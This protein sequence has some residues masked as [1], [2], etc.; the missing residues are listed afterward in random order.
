MNKKNIPELRFPEFDGEWE[1]KKLGEVAERITTKNKENNKNVLTIS[2][3]YGLINQLNFFNKSVSAKDLTGYYVLSKND[4]AYNKS[5]SNG[6]PM[7][8]F[9]RLTL[10]EKGVVSTLYICFR[11]KPCFSNEF[12]EHCFASGKQ[13]KEIYK[14]AQEGARN[15]GLLNIV[16]NDFFGINLT[17]PSLPEQTKIANFLT[18]VDKKISQLKQKKALLKEYKKGMMQ[19]IFSQKIRFKD[20]NGEDFAEW[21]LY[22]VKKILNKY[23]NPVKVEPDK[24]YSQIGIR[25]HGK[26]IF[27]KEPVSGLSL[28]NKRVFWIKENRL[29]LN[30]VFAWERAIS[31]TT[32]NEIGMIASHRFPM[33]EPAI[34][35]LNLDFILYLFLT[36]RGKLYLELASPGGAGRNKTLGQAQFE[37]LKISL[38][39]IEEQTK[40]ANFLTKLDEKINTVDSQ[41]K[42]TELWKKGLLQRMFCG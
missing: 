4:F 39:P 3:Q 21:K 33:Y 41:I 20:E 9:K 32:K 14:V 5:Y 29:I 34:G 25:S 23:S 22:P 27:Y 8:A 37:K 30:I 36:P 38:P 35:L 11:N 17:I 15:H 42:K 1:S 6:Y 10:Y 2:A 19:K 40:I 13:D 31:K 12:A 24:H 18:V 28:G 7:G 16:V 26:G